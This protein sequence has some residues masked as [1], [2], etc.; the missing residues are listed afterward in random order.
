LDCGNVHAHLGQGGSHGGRW[1]GPQC[2][3]RG[4]EGRHEHVGH[5]HWRSRRHGRH[6]GHAVDGIWRPQCPRI[7][8]NRFRRNMKRSL[9]SNRTRRFVRHFQ[10]I[11]LDIPSIHML[12]CLHQLYPQRIYPLSKKIRRHRDLAHTSSRRIRKSINERPLGLANLTEKIE[13]MF[14]RVF[15]GEIGDAE[16]LTQKR[17]GIPAGRFEK[18]GHGKVRGT[19]HWNVGD[20]G[21]RSGTTEVRTGV[22][23]SRWTRVLTGFP[24]LTFRSKGILTL[25]FHGGLVTRTDVARVR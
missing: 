3:L 8:D 25:T 19:G 5:G 22:W 9:M 2:H 16:R 12:Q 17:V 13:K 11:S 10:C 4:R 14:W 18:V 6:I 23:C 15:G 1:E 20:G 24:V 7:L 21:F